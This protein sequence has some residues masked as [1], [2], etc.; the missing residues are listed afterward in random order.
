V[1]IIQLSG[2][3]WTLSNYPVSCEHYSMNRFN[4]ATL[5]FAC[6]KA[7]HVYISAC[8]WSSLCFEVKGEPEESLVVV[9]V[10][11]HCVNFLWGNHRVPSVDSLTLP[12]EWTPGIEICQRRKIVGHVTIV[13]FH[14]PTAQWAPDYISTFLFF[15]IFLRYIFSFTPDVGIST[16]L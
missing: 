14:I 15:K 2:F 4:P 7:G 12:Y 16:T 9:F 5:Y 8:C 6:H 1:N 11:H 13:C 10:G 3:L